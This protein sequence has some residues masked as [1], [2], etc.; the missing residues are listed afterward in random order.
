[1]TDQLQA[2]I[3]PCQ[4][5][6]TNVSKMISCDRLTKMQVALLPPAHLYAKALPAIESPAFM[7]V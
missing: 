7:L 5:I 6:S 1:M 3:D 4:T 2:A